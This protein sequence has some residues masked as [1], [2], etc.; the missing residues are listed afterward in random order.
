MPS[1][2]TTMTNI[3]VFPKKRPRARAKPASPQNTTFETTATVV[4]TVLLR[5]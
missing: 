1:I 2:A 3:A 5:T 4:T